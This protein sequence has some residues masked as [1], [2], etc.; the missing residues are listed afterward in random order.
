MK[1][2]KPIVLTLHAKTRMVQ[3]GATFDE[4]QKALR[5]GKREQ[6]KRGKWHSVL[7]FEF[8]KASPLTGLIYTHKTVD[9]VFTEE[10]ERIVVL[11]TKVY[12]HND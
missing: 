10:T 3:R 2:D 1:K 8:D 9:I 11:T 7:K 6:A 12:Y 5:A 4:V